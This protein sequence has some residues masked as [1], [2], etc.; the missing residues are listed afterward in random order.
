MNASAKKATRIPIARIQ[1]PGTRNTHESTTPPVNTSDP[2]EW[3]RPPL[4]IAMA[5]TVANHGLSVQLRA[6]GV[7]SWRTLQGIPSGQGGAT[8]EGSAGTGKGSFAGSSSY[9]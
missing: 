5:W 4:W 9:Y 3:V 7:H 6:T 2:D 1:C 8:L